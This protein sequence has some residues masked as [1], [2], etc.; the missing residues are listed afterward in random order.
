MPL[1]EIRCWPYLFC[2]QYGYICPVCLMLRVLTVDSIFTKSIFTSVESVDSWQY[3]YKKCFY[4]RWECWQLTVFSQKVFYKCWQCWQLTVFSQK[5]FYK[6][7]ECWQYF[8]PKYS[9][10]LF[11]K[12]RVLTVD[13]F[14][15]KS[16][17]IYFYKLTVLRVDSFFQHFYPQQRHTPNYVRTH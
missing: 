8:L 16:T 11:R 5:V 3:F 13:S 7:W 17:Q 14:F 10:I 12:L 4:K 9:N 6:C 2:G 15:Y 1:C